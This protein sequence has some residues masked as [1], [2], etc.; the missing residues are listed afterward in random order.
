MTY[1][2]Q[3]DPKSLPYAP[4]KKTLLTSAFFVVR[5]K[6][7]E[8]FPMTACHVFSEPFRFADTFSGAFRFADTLYIYRRERAPSFGAERLRRPTPCHRTAPAANSLP[9]IYRE[10]IDFVSGL[11]TLCGKCVMY[12]RPPVSIQERRR[13]S[14]CT[15]PKAVR[16][17][18]GMIAERTRSLLI[19]FST[20]NDAD[21]IHT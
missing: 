20:C 1:Y 21:I 9:F 12:L 14:A 19:L 5:S 16:R 8:E 15:F 3:H 17:Q 6:Y 18:C 4:M 10:S 7:V 11:C 2:S 13:A